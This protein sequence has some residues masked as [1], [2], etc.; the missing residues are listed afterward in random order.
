MKTCLLIHGPN[1]NKLGQR[2]TEHYGELT[3]PE[4]ESIVCDY[5]RTKHIHMT[6]VQSNHEGVLIDTIQTH[7]ADGII[8]NPGAF[9]HYSYAIHDALLDRGIPTIEV[10]LSDLSAREPWRAH[11][12][13][14]PVCMKSV[15]GK[16]VAGYLEAVD[17]LAARFLD[18][19]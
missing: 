18:E 16:K 11:S 10:H 13:I 9:T 6:C 12:V 19:H 15:M 4:L 8:I 5:A 17:H 1:L 3:L 2:N 14:A 7:P